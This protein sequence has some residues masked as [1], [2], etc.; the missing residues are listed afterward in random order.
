MRR[1]G[2]TTPC[3][4]ASPSWAPRV[5]RWSALARPRPAKRLLTAVGRGVRRP[6]PA[7]V[8]P[9]VGPPPA[10]GRD[11]PR[12]LPAAGFS[13]ACVRA[14]HAD[15][16]LTRGRSSAA[17]REAARARAL[18]LLHINLVVADPEA[19]ARFY[20][21]HVLPAATCE[22][23]GNSLHVRSGVSDLAF[24]QGVPVVAKGTHHGFL[25]DSPGAIDALSRGLLEAG[26]A[27]TENEAEAGFRSIKFRDPDG[28]ECE[29][30]WEAD[31]P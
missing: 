14:R 27:L 20:V 1:A 5:R 22:W 29:V 23:L 6:W 13:R 3:S 10:S 28:Y 9:G 19:S 31:W 2:P 17:I 11:E 12:K 4:C 15:G 21:R 30:Y 26:I 8:G 16:S 25:A 24:Q 18:R 7:A